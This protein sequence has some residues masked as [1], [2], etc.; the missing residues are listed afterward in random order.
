MTHW[1]RAGFTLIELLVV[2]AI[3]GI[4]ASVVLA[5]LNR[6]RMH[7]RNTYMIS[8]VQEL[9]KAVEVYRTNNGY[10]PLFSS[11]VCV[12]DYDDGRCFSSNNFSENASFT[13]TMNPYLHVEAIAIPHQDNEAEGI[14]YR[15]VSGGAG[16]AISYILESTDSQCSIGA[17]SNSN[18]NATGN[19]VCS[20]CGGQCP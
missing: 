13:T 19:K 5:S 17:V 3:I 2:I 12:G 10:Y 15:A 14:I 8:T 20:V 1:R 18:L 6:T 7:S 9:I 11:Y 4:L 16:Y